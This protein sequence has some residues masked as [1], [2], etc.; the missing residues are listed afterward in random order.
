MGPIPG[1]AYFPSVL[2]NG[3]GHGI[4]GGVECPQPCVDDAIFCAPGMSAV[5]RVRCGSCWWVSAEYLL[6]W[7]PSAQLPV[8]VTTSPPASNGILGAP[9]TAVV[10]GGGPFGETRHTGARFGGGWWFDDSQCRGI[11]GRIFFLGR[12]GSGFTANTTQYPLLARPF[13]NLNAPVGPFSEL[14]GAPGLAVGSVAVNLESSVWGAEANF[15]RNLVCNPCSRLDGLIGYRYLNFKESLTITEAF[16]RTPDSPMTVG[17]PATVGM[18]TDQFQTENN[19]HGGQIGLTGEV[20]RGRWFV[21]GR[22]S[23]AFGTTFQTA[24]IGGGQALG[25]ANGQVA[26]FQ[27]GLLAVPGANIGT[28][29]QDKFAVLPE[30]GVNLGYHLT[31]HLRVF[32]G[33]NFL[34]LSSV[35]RPGDVINT[36]IDAARIPNFPLPNPVAPLP[37]VPQPAPLLRTTD[38]WAQGISFGLQF[39]W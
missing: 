32:V 31:P 39:T 6:W 34:Y 11:D 35:L 2:P 1:G 9:G 23:V 5:D 8:L 21:D 14:V 17:V 30:V 4:G 29:R 22:A 7:T 26:Q 15:R 3:N 27:G 19:F 10:F 37:G 38:F 16:V 20:R 33:Y 28:F 36:N 18:I 12:N 13:F 25:F 24:T